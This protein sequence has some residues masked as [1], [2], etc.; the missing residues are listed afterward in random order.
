[1][2]REKLEENPPADPGE[3]NKQLASYREQLKKYD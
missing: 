3:L 1:M 2:L